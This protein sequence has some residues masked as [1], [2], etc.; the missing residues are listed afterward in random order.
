MSV[1]G[2]QRAEPL[3]REWRGRRQ[4]QNPSS[5]A[6]PVLALSVALDS[7]VAEPRD[8]CR[9]RRSTAL[10]SME[11]KRSP[12][13]ACGV[14]IAAETHRRNRPN[15]RRRGGFRLRGAETEARS[16]AAAAEGQT[17]TVAPRLE[18]VRRS[19]RELPGRS[20][21]SRRKTAQPAC[22]RQAESQWGE[23]GAWGTSVRQK[24]PSKRSDGLRSTKPARS[25]HAGEI[26]RC[27]FEVAII[28]PCRLSQPT[29]PG[30]VPSQP[31]QCN[32][33]RICLAGI[34]GTVGIYL[35]RHHGR[36]TRPMIAKRETSPGTHCR[37]SS[38]T[39]GLSPRTK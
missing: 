12:P 19:E 28:P 6:R 14:R 21:H 4:G 30:A 37:L 39:G 36:V 16:A 9:R 29:G 17:K 8:C 1:V 18:R 10:R 5:R 7:R 25:H 35:R 15:R 38:E 22:S 33:R 32:P 34:S 13:R 23:S 31:K 24:N 2:R 26:V 27:E 3:V 20:D 11:G